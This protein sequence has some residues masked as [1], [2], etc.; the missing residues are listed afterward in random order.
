MRHPLGKR[1]DQKRGNPRDPRQHG[2]AAA[3][4]VSF[5]A[6]SF[7]PAKATGG[8]RVLVDLSGPA[9]SVIFVQAQRVPILNV[10]KVVLA[11][12]AGETPLPIQVG[13]ADAIARNS[14]I[15]IRGLPPAAALTEGHSIAPGAW[16][17]PIIA[18]PNLKITL[19]VGLSG[20]SDVTVALVTVD[21]TVVAETKTALVIAATALIA[22]SETE[23]QSKNVASLGPASS[24][25]RSQEPATRP[26]APQKTSPMTEEQ[27]RALPFISRGNEQL[28][29]G[30]VAA[31]RLFFQ[32]AADAG[33]AQGA[34]ALAAT[35]DPSE[36]DRI[37]ARFVQPD[38]QIARKWYQRARQLGALEAEER[39]EQL[40]SR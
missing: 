24:A 35:Y 17:I 6:L 1:G 26:Q 34:L 3:L 12:P 5:C 31:A 30:N 21:G 29:Q 4:L 19:P 9:P 14:F 16:A 10:S 15:R 39:L 28:G 22:P 27:Q 18:L 25:V 33:L 11:E 7:G 36:L 37:G 13:P 40:G 2:L 38:T 32:R 20:K 8:A 23:P